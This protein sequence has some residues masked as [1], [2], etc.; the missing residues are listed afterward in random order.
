M[1]EQTSQLMGTTAAMELLTGFPNGGRIH[2]GQKKGRVRPQCSVVKVGILK[3][4]PTDRSY[5]MPWWL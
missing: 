4:H 1:D 5:F 2:D 3:N